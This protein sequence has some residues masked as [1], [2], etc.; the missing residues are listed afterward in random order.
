MTTWNVSL[1]SKLQ[2]VMLEE[3]MFDALLNGKEDFVHL[4]VD[5]GVQL[6]QFLTIQRLRAMYRASL[7]QK[8]TMA[9]IFKHLLQ[10]AKVSFK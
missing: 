5:N 1:A 6:T 7:D 2:N 4:F 9:A 3:A 8:D 10:K